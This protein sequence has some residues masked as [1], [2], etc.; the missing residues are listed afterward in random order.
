MYVLHSIA[1]NV[2][3]HLTILTA[4]ESVTSGRTSREVKDLD[5]TNIIRVLYHYAGAVSLDDE[6]Y[7]P[8]GQVAI[9]GYVDSSL[10]SLVNKL[11]IALVTGNTCLIVPHKDTPLSAYM[12]LD[13]CIQSGVPA[14]VINLICSDKADLVKWISADARI[15][16]VSFD[17]RLQVS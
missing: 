10:L 11:A 17:G 16:A 6:N 8:V 2:Q 14:G 5:I 7:E 12:F 3:K 15:N 9:L 1:R 13:I 4:C